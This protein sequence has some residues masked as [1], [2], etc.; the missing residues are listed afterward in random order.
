[1]FS[2]MT[3]AD[4]SLFMGVQGGLSGP[5]G[6][7][8]SKLQSWAWLGNTWLGTLHP[9]ALPVKF[10]PGK[11]I[12]ARSQGSHATKLPES[13]GA[14]GPAVLFLLHRGCSLK[15][16]IITFVTLNEDKA[17]NIYRSISSF[18]LQHDL[19]L[20][21]PAYFEVTSKH[22]TLVTELNLKS[23]VLIR[24]QSF[25]CFM[26]KISVIPKAQIVTRS[27]P[28]HWSVCFSTG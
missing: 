14:W 24:L 4:F 10:R 21:F 27:V 1:M 3:T 6:S 22:Q 16:S 17:W 23:L 12:H 18:L 26:H 8:F 2:W 11:S 28:I 20:N 19:G 13:W 25:K 15:A 9:K 5:K 7:C